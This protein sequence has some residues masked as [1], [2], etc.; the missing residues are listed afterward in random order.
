MGKM[1]VGGVRGLRAEVDRLRTDIEALGREIATAPRPGLRAALA[2]RR[3]TYGRRLRRLAEIMLAAPMPRRELTPLLRRQLDAMGATERDREW[4]SG[5]APCPTF[6][7]RD[8]ELTAIRAEW[9]GGATEEAADDR[10]GGA[11]GKA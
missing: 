2:A 1:E 3:E 4:M 5:R 6:D 8:G 11:H 10:E 9:Y 7:G